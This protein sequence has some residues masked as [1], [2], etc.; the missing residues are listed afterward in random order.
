MSAPVPEPGTA[1]VLVELLRRRGSVPGSVVVD[2]AGGG[3]VGGVGGGGVA[4]GEALGE[5]LVASGF[6]VLAV[7]PDQ[8]S[9]ELLT[10]MGAEVVA[11]TGGVAGFA[12]VDGFGGGDGG[13]G[14]FDA[15]THALG[16]R[17]VAAVWL[18]DVPARV[19]DMAGLLGAVHRFCARTGAL[20]ALDVPNV[21][22][23]D[24][25]TK[26]LLGRWEPRTGGVLD[27]AHVRHFTA[28]S[29]RSTMNSLGWA[30][31]D[32]EDLASA[33]SDQH[34]PTDA[35]PLE[36]TT[37]SGA[38]LAALREMAGPGAYVTSLVRLYEAVT[39]GAPE[40]GASADTGA[41]ADVPFLSVLVRTQGKRWETLQ[42]TLLCLAAQSCSDF[43]VIVLVHDPEPDVAAHI[44][45]L[46]AEFH[47]SFSRR[48][49]VVEV[50]GGGRCRPLNVGAREARGH[51]LATLDD[52]DLVFAHWVETLRATAERAPGHAL[53]VGV[54]AQQIAATRGSWADGDGYDV[55]SRPR[56][57]YPLTFDHIEHLRDNLTPN[58]GYAVPRWVAIDLGQ[59][60]DESLPVLEDW[61]H[62]LRFAAICGVA[63]TPTV[64]AMLRVWA[65]AE[66]SKTMHSPE[67]WEETRQRIVAQHDAQPLLL[68]IGYVSRLQELLRRLDGIPDLELQLEV[69]AQEIAQLRAE[70]SRLTDEANGLA[71]ELAQANSRIAQ[72]NSR[73]DQLS[74]E[75]VQ[76]RDEIERLTSEAIRLAGELAQ[77]NSRIDH[78]EAEAVQLRD[79]I[80]RLTGVAGQFEGEAIRLAG[81][82]ATSER[83]RRI[84]DE[85]VE[86]LE[87]ARVDL[88][89]RL[90]EVFASRSWRLTE[91]L[92]KGTGA[93]RRVASAPQRLLR[94][95]GRH[96]GRGE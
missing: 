47:P 23:V 51:Y 32:A 65:N 41:G 30:E 52:D 68:D 22:H 50:R 69:R 28:A 57:D 46:L 62:L 35:V 75:A 33:R 54:A 31:V 34:F 5:A 82:L 43:E 79:E 18:G 42:E 11:G 37:P 24:V 56:V 73:I 15:V 80:E 81:E 86:A 4:L 26:L 74:A 96:A 95:A 25:G 6:A 45:E 92:R 12:G 14:V 17:H 13:D 58:N 7:A 83:H 1:Q 90:D 85:S 19:R 60:W 93:V 2:L 55:V 91:A 9:A 78:L 84:A 89:A 40:S 67:V 66:N 71:G 48:T 10:S 76:L 59:E 20:L 44:E 63:S 64:A 70:I 88:Q 3:G 77:S 29:L 36:R 49:R 21:S 39:P 8:P 94:R 87:A 61:D 72:S 16:E 38:Q 53:R 27:G